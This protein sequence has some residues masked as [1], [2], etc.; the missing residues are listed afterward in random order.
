[1]EGAE[2]VALI[3]HMEGE[4]EQQNS[5]WMG[6]ILPHRARFFW[7]DIEPAVPRPTCPGEN[8]SM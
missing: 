5:L 6:V 4:Y 1:M 3:H 8:S 2:G 7:M